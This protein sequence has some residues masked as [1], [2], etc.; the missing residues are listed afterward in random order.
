V[1]ETLIDEIIGGC[2]SFYNLT[3]EEKIEFAGKQLF[4]PIRYGTSFNVKVDKTFFWRDYLKL[5]VH[6]NFNA[7]HKP[8]GFRYLKISSNYYYYSRS[9]KLAGIEALYISK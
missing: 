6:P 3:E 8:A 9:T 1:P 4:D 7:P 2:N 5:W